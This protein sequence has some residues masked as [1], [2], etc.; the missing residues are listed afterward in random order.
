MARVLLVSY[1]GYPST[2]AHLVANPWL[3]AQAGAL[4]ALGH[5]VLALDYG[6]VSMMRRLYPEALT[7]QLR[8]LAAGMMGGGGSGIDE[9]GVRFLQDVSAKLDAHQEQQT[10]DLAEELVAQVSDYRPGL[11]MLELGDGDHYSG[12]VRLAARLKDQ[13]PELLLGAGGRKACWFRGLVLRRDPVFDAVVF[14]EAEEAV[15]RLAAVAEGRGT[16]ETVPGIAYR[17]DGGVIENDCDEPG[18][19][20]NLPLPLYDTAVYPAMLGDEKIKMAI[21]SESRGCNNRCGFCLHPW[22]DG[23]RQRLASAGKI[24]DTM[25][26]L[27][28]YY[29]MSVF[30]FGGASTPGELMYEIAG[31]ILRRGLK[32]QYNSFGHF[33]SAN[34]DHFELLAKSGLYSLFFGLESGC[35]EVLDKAVHKGIRLEKVA[36]TMRA[37]RSAGLFSAASMIVPLPFDTEETLAESLRFVIDLQPDAV[38]LQFPGLMP[39]TRWIAEPGKYNIEVGDVE[40]FL[41]DGL[42]YRIKLLFPPQFWTPLAYRGERDVVR[43]VHGGHDPV[44]GAA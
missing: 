13:F 26:V 7:N 9:S 19:L 6:T 37:A 12:T 24:V 23:G 4:A 31:E 30:R 3:A 5:E 40:R 20:D 43:G 33:R 39:G 25:S 34:P 14:G 2:P 11:V 29:G 16:L 41:L 42:D 17:T 36:E 18:D 32:V 8:P 44:R 27:Q 21:I 15:L 28:Q 38:P 1:P 35:Q 10:A 22:E